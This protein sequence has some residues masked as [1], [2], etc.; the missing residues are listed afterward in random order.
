MKHLNRELK[1]HSKVRLIEEEQSSNQEACSFGQDEICE[2]ETNSNVLPIQTLSTDIKNRR[3]IA[4]LL[5][6]VV[7]KV[8]KRKKK[9]HNIKFYRQNR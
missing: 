5:K 9:K 1:R 8:N 7:R 6:S 4:L 2:F 3:S